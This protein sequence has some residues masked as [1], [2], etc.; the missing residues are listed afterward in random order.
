MDRWGEYTGI[1]ESCPILR[2]A[3]KN[4]QEMIWMAETGRRTM[5]SEIAILEEFA[6]SAK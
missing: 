2:V 3:F 6:S 5:G 4:F 1:C